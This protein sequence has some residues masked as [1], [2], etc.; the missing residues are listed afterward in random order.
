MNEV[1][2]TGQ[3]ALHIAVHQGHARIVERL[4]GFGINLDLQDS[5]GD[6]ALHIALSRDNAK[7]LSAETPQLKKVLPF[8][9]QWNP[10]IRRPQQCPL[11]G[12]YNHVYIRIGGN[13]QRVQFSWLLWPI[14]YLK[15][16]P[17]KKCRCTSTCWDDH[18][19]SNRYWNTARLSMKN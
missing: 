2:E 11:A 17:L 1:T 10:C 18:T 19:H 12:W 15:L 4:V 13:F 7:T 6:T 8:S 16:S 9:V 14:D 5:D 3:T